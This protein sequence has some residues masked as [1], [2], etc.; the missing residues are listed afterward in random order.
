MIRYQKIKLL[1]VFK[2]RKNIMVDDGKEENER[3]I[4]K[5]IWHLGV[6]FWFEAIKE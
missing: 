5:M 6:L 1:A 4:A 2:R 3:K